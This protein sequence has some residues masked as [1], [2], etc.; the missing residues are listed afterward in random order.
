MNKIHINIIY[1]FLQHKAHIWNNR[2]YRV[3]GINTVIQSY[4]IT[5]YYLTMQCQ[6]CTFYKIKV[7]GKMSKNLGGGQDY[8]TDSTV[9]A[10]TLRDYAIRNIYIYIYINSVTTE[11][12]L[13]KI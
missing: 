3:V 8:L 4:K 6:R 5:E 13:D 1:I 7:V 10:F 12:T 11:G 9:L 2:I